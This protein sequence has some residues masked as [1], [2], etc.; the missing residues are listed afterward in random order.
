MRKEATKIDPV[1]VKVELIRRESCIE[2]WAHE[3]GYVPSTVWRSV[4]NKHV[5]EISEQI[6][7]QLKR[8]LGL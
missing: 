5:G 7:R 6:R 4:H 8:Q 3:H 1:E 2:Q